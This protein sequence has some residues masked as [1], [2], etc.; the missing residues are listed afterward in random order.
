MSR[1]AMRWNGDFNNE[2]DKGYPSYAGNPMWFQLP[3]D[4]SDVIRVLSNNNN[5]N[6]NTNRQ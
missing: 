6:N 2:D 3:Y 4:I 1:I 5:N